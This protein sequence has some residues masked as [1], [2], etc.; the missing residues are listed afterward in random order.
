MGDTIPR[1]KCKEG[2][3]YKIHSRNLSIGV[4]HQKRLGDSKFENGFVGI[5]EK[6]GELFLFIPCG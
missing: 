1:E 6:F 3:A 2:Y 4:F 5:R